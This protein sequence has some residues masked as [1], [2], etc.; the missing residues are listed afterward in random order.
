MPAARSPRPAT[1]RGRPSSAEA[2]RLGELILTASWELLL[3]EGFARFS[4]DRLARSARVGKPTIYARFADKRA[5][6]TAL[7]DQRVDAARQ[8]LLDAIGNDLPAVEGLARLVGGTVERMLSP[9][10]RLLDRLADWLDQESD[11][12]ADVPPVCASA[13][14]SGSQ[15]LADRVAAGIAA[16][17]IG[18]V[19]PNVAASLLMQGMIGRARLSTVV[20]Q[21]D[22]AAW[23]RQFTRVILTGL[24]H[25]SAADAGLA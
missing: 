10:G 8:Q 12:P 11:R 18:P 5:L 4:I 14:A 22:L 7:F 9:E 25:D 1:R 23:S 19:D 21:G 15:R 16:R 3:S 2:E 24:S 13:Y 6:L 20:D 17:E